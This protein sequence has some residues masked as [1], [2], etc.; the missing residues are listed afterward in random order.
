[1]SEN[2]LHL[3]FAFRTAQATGV[4]RST[5]E[6]FLV[7]E[8]PSAL[9][10]GAG[11][12]VLLQIEKR[13]SNTDWVAG[14]LA[15]YANVPRR[16][17]SYA[18]MKDRHAVTRQWFSV[19]LAGRLEPDWCALVSEEFKILQH[20]RH[21]RKLKIGALKGNR[22]TIRVKDF[23]G[24]AGALAETLAKLSE[25]GMPN[26]FGEQRFGIDGEN[27]EFAKKLFNGE[28][29]KVPRQ[30]KGFYLSAARS[31]LFNLVLAERVRRKNWNQPINGDRFILDGSRSSFLA[32]QIDDELVRRIAEH[33]IH[34]S[35]PLWG[36]GDIKVGG[37]AAVLEQSVLEAEHLLQGGLVQFGLSMERRALRASVHQLSWSIDD[38]V[39]TL[40][41]ELPK[42]VFATA[43]LREC[44]DY[45]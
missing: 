19:R 8:M 1:M 26:Y 4:I 6:D 22:F 35:G 17:V 9:P 23:V 18:G 7:E 45:L 34:V 39:L 41:F 16:D 11:E 36:R 38:G 28:L 5:P 12:H 32:D 24:D 42:G 33:D 30:K 40:C 20:D 29:G 13:N 27:L 25:L 2:S 15:R 10:D 44:C 37:D 31:Y 43:L 3:P 21:S 14:Q